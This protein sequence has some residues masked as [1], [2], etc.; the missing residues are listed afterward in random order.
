MPSNLRSA[1][2]CYGSWLHWQPGCACS[3]TSSTSLYP[4]WLLQI[5]VPSTMPPAPCEQRGS[6]IL[7]KTCAA[8]FQASSR[9]RCC[10]GARAIAGGSP[11][12]SR[13]S[14]VSSCLQPNS[15]TR[16]GNSLEQGASFYKNQPC[17]RECTTSSH[18]SLKPN[19][20]T[21]VHPRGFESCAKVV[22]RPNW[23][24]RRLKVIDTRHSMCLA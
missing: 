8:C 13:S 2:R 14:Y 16:S 19:L 10:S 17:G 9:L 23:S 21:R 6:P 12:G 22:S 3:C 15:R 24:S 7:P 5:D 20:T 1:A 4:G 11:D 18:A